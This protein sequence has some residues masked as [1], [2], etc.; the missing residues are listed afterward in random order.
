MEL[1]GTGK[2]GNRTMVYTNIL[3]NQSNQSNQSIQS[4]QSNQSNLT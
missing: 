1:K 3:A 4:N 2:H